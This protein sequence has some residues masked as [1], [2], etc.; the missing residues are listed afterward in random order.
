M[1]L[2]IDDKY[3]NTY[4]ISALAKLFSLPNDIIE[5]KIEKIFAR[6]GQ[7]TVDANI[8]IFQNISEKLEISVNN[9]F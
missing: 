6:K 3:D 9:T 7:I 8:K 5:K 1:L 2:E 4:L